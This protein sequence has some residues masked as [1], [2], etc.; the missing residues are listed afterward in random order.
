MKT[1]KNSF[2]VQTRNFIAKC[3][4]YKTLNILKTLEKA[5]RKK[6]QTKKPLNHQ[7]FYLFIYFQSNG[8]PE[9][10]WFKENHNCL[11]YFPSRLL[12]LFGLQCKLIEGRGKIFTF[13]GMKI[14]E[15]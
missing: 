15:A 6:S 8:K 1:F 13:L 3:T 5:K 10:I 2:N 11:Q 12:Q 9:A 7:I 14:K 4:V